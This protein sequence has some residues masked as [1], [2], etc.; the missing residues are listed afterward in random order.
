MVKKTNKKG[1]RLVLLIGV[2][3]YTNSD[4]HHSLVSDGENGNHLLIASL[5]CSGEWITV[6][7]YN[8]IGYNYCCLVATLCLTLLWLYRLY[9]SRLLCPWDFPEYWSELLLPS[10]GDLPD[11]GIEPMSPALADGF[12]ITEP[13]GS[14]K[15][16]YRTCLL[17][18]SH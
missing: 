8:G 18:F 12:F 5:N 11:P 1:W 6:Y 17:L 2:D 13:P 4:I 3:R 15:M 9:F 10:P 14:W 7:W 16:F